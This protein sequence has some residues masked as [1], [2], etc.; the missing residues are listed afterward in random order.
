MGFLDFLEEKKNSSDESEDIL[1]KE[2]IKSDSIIK[3]KENFGKKIKI[4]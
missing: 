4:D 1:I 3:S 2:I